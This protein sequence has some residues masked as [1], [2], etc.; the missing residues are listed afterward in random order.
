MKNLFSVITISLVY[1]TSC[2]FKTQFTPT[3]GSLARK[4]ITSIPAQF[5]W[6]GTGSG[7]VTVTMPDGEVCNGRYSTIARGTRSSHFGSHMSSYHGGSAY[8]PYSR[9]MHGYGAYSGSSSHYQNQQYGQ[10][11][12]TGN[13]GRVIKFRYTTSMDSPT[14]GHGSGSDNRGNFYSIVF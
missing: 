14:H 2:T 8:S 5:T 4:G 7:K 12:L 3:S 13:R 9:S 11:I 6:N 10:G 1:L